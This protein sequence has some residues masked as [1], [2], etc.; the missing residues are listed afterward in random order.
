VIAA[1]GEEADVAV[2]MSGEESRYR[3]FWLGGYHYY[4]ILQLLLL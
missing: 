3:G 4:F 2:R 1:A